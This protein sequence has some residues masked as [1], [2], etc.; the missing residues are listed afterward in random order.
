MAENAAVGSNV[1][2]AVT[3][4]DSDSDT[5]TYKLVG[6][7]VVAFDIVSGTGQLQVGAALDH[8]TAGSYTVTVQA[9]DGKSVAFKDVT[10]TVTGV[11]EL[12]ALS[13]DAAPAV[14]DD[15]PGFVAT[16]AVTD[17]E[18][19]RV[20]AVTWSLAGADSSH[21]AID[22][23]RLRFSATPDYEVS[24]HGADYA[25]TVQAAVAGQQGSPFTLAVTATVVNVDEAGVVS[26]STEQPEV[27]VALTATLSDP[28]GGVSGATWK[29]AA[30]TSKNGA[31]INISGATSAVYTPA[32]ADA[33]HYL[34]ATA[35]YGDAEGTGKSARGVSDN[36]L[37]GGA[38]VTVTST[39]LTI[40]EG[41]S[42][43]YT[44]VLD[45][46]PSGDATVTIVDP[47][48]NTD[49]TA[50]PASLTFTTTNWNTAQT[51][52][53]SAGQDDDTSDDTATVTHTVSGYGTVSTAPAV[54]VTVTDNDTPGVTVTPTELSFAE[55]G[56][57]TYTVVL[58]TQPTDDVTIG[59]ADDSPEVDVLPSSLTFSTSNWATAQTVTVSAASDGDTVSDTATVSHTVNGG[60]YAGLNASSV[61]VTVTDTSVRGITFP[62]P[63]LTVVEGSTN[64][65]TVVLNTIPTATVTVG[66]ASSSTADVTTSASTLTFTAATWNSPQKVTVTAV[67]DEIDEDA[68]T[69]SL[70]HTA[71]GGDYGSVTAIFNVQVDDNDTRGMTV[72][73]VSLMVNEGGSGTY[74][75][76]LKTQPTSDVTVT[77]N[78]P[79]NTDVTADPASLTFSTSNWATAQTVTVSAAEDN[80]LS[81][82]IATVTHT[83]AGGDYESFA[84]PSVAVIVTDNDVPGVTVT[85]TSL[86]IAEGG[87]GTYTVTLN[88]LPAGDVTVAIVDPTD[89][90]DVTAEPASL[91]FT[92]TNW[93][94]AQTV[95]V[96]AVQDT[97]ATDDTATVT[98]TVSGYGSVVTGASVTVT[99]T[100]DDDPTAPYDTD[101]NGAIDKDEASVAVRS[102]LSD[103]TPTKEVASAVVRRYLSG[104]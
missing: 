98:H 24:G 63:S 6:A 35:S 19:D 57:G 72:S 25:V 30:A 42:G 15:G 44:V 78:D 21:F 104:S 68:K 23:G 8:E 2:A 93:S 55:G 103:G 80:D 86:T 3:A 96:S 64:T 40:G 66:I 26:L 43:T 4:T 101:G 70:T 54:S 100:D 17:P 45:A 71:S 50:E 34:R 69:V 18:G 58:D 11:N 82:D 37:S 22:N 65:Y 77:V 81:R 51:V 91:T 56:S 67:H 90:T 9:S 27:G 52:T 53:V 38:G 88:T 95:T 5:L 32:M 16:Y 97:D 49:V 13:G 33:G 41:G 39:S 20:G 89:N 61:A 94:T 46:E 84:A 14:A 47:T 62:F 36:P 59:V 76:K 28:D 10:V 29:W 85:P 87:S 7:G 1:G 92:T 73:A 74:T 48:D 75:V 60:D 102:Y 31:W 79:T 83:L 12:P 99:V